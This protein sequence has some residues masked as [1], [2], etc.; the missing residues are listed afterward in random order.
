[1]QKLADVNYWKLFSTK[2]FLQMLQCTKIE[3][4]N[5]FYVCNALWEKIFPS[6]IKKIFFTLKFY[7]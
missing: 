3:H 1:M 4:T 6:S 2:I 5:I 7:M